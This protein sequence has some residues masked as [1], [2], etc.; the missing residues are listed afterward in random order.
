MRDCFFCVPA[1]VKLVV[2]TTTVGVSAALRTCA[3]PAKAFRIEPNALPTAGFHMP[4][5]ASFFFF[6]TVTSSAFDNVSASEWIAS[7]IATKHAVS[8]AVLSAASI[9]SRGDARTSATVSA[10]PPDESAP[11][12]GGGGAVTPSAPVCFSSVTAVFATVAVFS[13]VVSAGGCFSA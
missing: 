2:I 4:L 5:H 7:Q 6:D 3:R 13:F 8:A 12:D 11:G 9:T 10:A 1:F